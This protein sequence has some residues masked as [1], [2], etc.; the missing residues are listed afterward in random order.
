[1][2]NIYC[3]TICLYVILNESNNVNT[4]LTGTLIC[5]IK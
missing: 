4:I 2:F 3:F 1:M 5:Y